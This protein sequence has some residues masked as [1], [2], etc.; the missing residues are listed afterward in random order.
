MERCGR[1]KKYIAEGEGRYHIPVD[2]KI[3]CCEC[4]EQKKQYGDMK[5]L[6]TSEPETEKIK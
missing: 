4:M 5:I 2:E 6:A 3:L 1:C